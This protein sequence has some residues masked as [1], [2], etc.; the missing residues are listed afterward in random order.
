MGERFVPGQRVKVVFG[1]RIEEGIITSDES[2][3]IDLPIPMGTLTNVGSGK[4][5]VET[6][7]SDGKP[8][9]AGVHK[10]HIQR[11]E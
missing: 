4:Y 9:T 3:G 11:G 10:S 6:I 1:E 7:M 2:E 5:Q 8:S